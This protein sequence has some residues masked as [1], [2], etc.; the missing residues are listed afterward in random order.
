MVPPYPRL[1]TLIG[2]IAGLIGGGSLEPGAL[3]PTVRQLAADL[4]VAPGTLARATVN[5]KTM[6]GSRAEADTAPSCARTGRSSPQ[7]IANV[8]CAPKPKSSS[9]PL[10]PS[11][12]PTPKSSTHCAQPSA[13]DASPTSVRP[14][15]IETRLNHQHYRPVNRPGLH[16]ILCRED[17]V[18]GT[19]E[20]V[21]GSVAGSGG[22]PGERCDHSCAGL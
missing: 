13:A 4:G 22:S 2:Q 21:S 9:P 18:D 14:P 10:G 17:E 19:S 15:P 8:D 11:A 12:R 1:A 3:L 20:G 6:A 16:S 7:H 5:E